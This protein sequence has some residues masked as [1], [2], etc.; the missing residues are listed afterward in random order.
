MAI[1]SVRAGLLALMDEM[2]WSAKD[3]AACVK[4]QHG[5]RR[6]ERYRVNTIRQFL[7]GVR[8]DIYY[9]DLALAILAAFP[10]I[11]K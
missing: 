9:S 11:R 2:S 1:E 8:P 5:R 7:E 4:I 3:V 10:A 6:G